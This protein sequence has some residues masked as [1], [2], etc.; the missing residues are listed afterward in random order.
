[1]QRHECRFP[2]LFSSPEIVSL[3]ALQ[4]PIIVAQKPHYFCELD[5]LETVRR[6][7]ELEPPFWRSDELRA[8]LED[9]HLVLMDTSFFTRQ[10]ARGH[11][12]GDRGVLALLGRF[13]GEGPW[14]LLCQ[15]LLPV[16]PDGALLGVTSGL[17]PPPPRSLQELPFS[18]LSAASF[19]ST[20]EM[21]LSCRCLLD[22]QRALEGLRAADRSGYRELCEAADRVFRKDAAGCSWR[23]TDWVDRALDSGA[24]GCRL[25]SYACLRFALETRLRALTGEDLAGFVSESL[26]CRCQRVGGE[27]AAGE[28][29]SRRRRR[30]KQKRRRLQQPDGLEDPA[31]LFGDELLLPQEAERQHGEGPNEPLFDL[32][33]PP[34]RTGISARDL[35]LAL[36]E[37]LD[38]LALARLAPTSSLTTVS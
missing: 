10:L 23:P 27:D 2:P 12:D 8:S 4:T 13:L 5:V 16:L 29:G 24:G 7:V 25:G 15:R 1:M 36:L 3:L 38:S 33:I 6:L 21:L 19:R 37:H 31:E 34:R 11:R 9:G 14:R 35:V 30:R 32:D 20:G 18:G 17:L 22:G 28:E 26:G